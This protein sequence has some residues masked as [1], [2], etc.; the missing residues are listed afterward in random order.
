MN[1]LFSSWDKGLQFR[2]S[3]PSLPHEV[4]GTSC[5]LFQLFSPREQLAG[6]QIVPYDPV[7]FSPEAERG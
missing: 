7:N 3:L 5:S 1:L 2:S 4:I 6:G